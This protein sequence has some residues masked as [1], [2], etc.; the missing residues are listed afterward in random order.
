M[1]VDKNSKL[2]CTFLVT[3]ATQE[4]AA[5]PWSVSQ[6]SHF[7]IAYIS[8][9]Q[10]QCSP[11]VKTSKSQSFA[12]IWYLSLF[13]IEITTTKQRQKPSLIK[14]SKYAFLLSSCR[15]CTEERRSKVVFFITRPTISTMK[16]MEN[17][18]LSCWDKS[19]MLVLICNLCT[20]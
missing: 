10:C 3:K 8:A 18:K 1:W 6:K 2:L 19:I 20:S 14:A 11:G 5:L 7:S 12:T 13:M 16:M 15:C 4:L 17:C 9:C